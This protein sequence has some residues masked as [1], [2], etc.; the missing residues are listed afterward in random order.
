MKYDCT[1][2]VLRL[3]SLNTT[4]LFGIEQLT[5]ASG[6]EELKSECLSKSAAYVAEATST[7]EAGREA[8][9]YQYDLGFEYVKQLDIFSNFLRLVNWSM[10]RGPCFLVVALEVPHNFQIELAPSSQDNAC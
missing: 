10:V 8:I 3:S 6:F 2:T 5:S 1:D 7:P 4:G 9:Q